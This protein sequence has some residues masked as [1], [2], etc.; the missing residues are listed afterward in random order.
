MKEDILEQLVEDY[1]VSKPGWFV[2]HNVKYRPDKNQPNYNSR[3]D[4]IHSE[5]DIIAVNRISGDVE[6][7]SCKS[8]LKG[9]KIKKMI[10]YIETKEI[11]E[12]REL[13]SE[14]WKE[15]FLKTIEE[16]TGKKDFT[17]VIA[18]TKLLQE[19]KKSELERKIKEIFRTQDSKVEFKILKLEEIVNEA[20]NRITPRPESTDAGR[21]T[22]LFNAANII[23]FPTKTEITVKRKTRRPARARIRRIR[24][25]RL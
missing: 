3:Q 20:I 10:K 18:V 19:E 23:K 5:I 25:M 17:Y 12:S 14:K 4:S 1:Y 8:R 22:Q 13:L 7:V 2:K 24:R 21:I 11:T 6:V 16:E 9:L 15:A